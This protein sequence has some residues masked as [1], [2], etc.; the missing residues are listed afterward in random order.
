[1]TPTT[2]PPL[3]PLP[4]N[5]RSPSAASNGSTTSS[6]S[7][8]SR[9]ALI[10]IMR[11]STGSFS[12]RSDRSPPSSYPRKTNNDH[13]SARSTS[14]H[15]PPILPPPG[16]SFS[17][18]FHLPSP[19]PRS[20]YHPATGLI[21]GEGGTPPL[22]YSTSFTALPF[23]HSTLFPMPRKGSDSDTETERTEA[24][25]RRPRKPR[26]VSALPGPRTSGRTGW[27]GEGWNEVNQDLPLPSPRTS[28]GGFAASTSSTFQRLGSLSKKH[29]RRLSGGFGFG[30][31]SH[32]SSTE[33]I[34]VAGLPTVMGS[35]SKPL[36]K[37]SPE[38]E[39]ER[40]AVRAGSVSAPSSV[41]KPTSPATISS[42][43]QEKQRRRQSLH[44]FIPKDIME[45]QKR[46]REGIDAVTRF[47]QGL[48][49]ESAAFLMYISRR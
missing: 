2:A 40:A 42:K 8:H 37:A 38:I 11:R 19:S 16:R 18:G 1:M 15:S 25:P 3:P 28:S 44:D 26:P 14:L 41:I 45:K 21:P 24:T 23:P 12:K 13:S 10:S 20:P 46:Y 36:R 30:T 49:S 17:R 47:A 34:L 32:S 6:S 27:E 22:P 9:S 43:D 35:P 33:S 7:N 48:E 39:N 5:L 29:G 31:N 4:P